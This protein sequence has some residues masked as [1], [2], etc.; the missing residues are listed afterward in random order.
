M[1][2]VSRGRA[3]AGLV[4]VV[5][6]SNQALQILAQLILEA[7]VAAKILATPQLALA[8]LAS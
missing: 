1:G 3:L 2:V 5:L 4:V 7:A 8:A 6:G